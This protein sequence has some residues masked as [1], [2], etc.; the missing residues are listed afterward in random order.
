MKVAII[1]S[2]E[3]RD[4]LKIKNFI[5]KLIEKYGDELE[6]VSGGQPKGAD[7]FA[8][9]FAVELGAKYVEF[10]PEHFSFNQHCGDEPFNYGKP[11]RVY[12]YL[13]RN[14]KIAKYADIVVAFIPKNWKIEDSRGTNDTITKAKKMGKKVLVLY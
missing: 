4:S 1:G 10:P 7:G 2:R 14:T 6:I 3:Y 8:K 12:H 5:R 13:Q 11:Y 9:K